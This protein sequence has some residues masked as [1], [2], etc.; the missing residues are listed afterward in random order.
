MRRIGQL[1]AQPRRQETRRTVEIDAALRQQAP[2]DLRHPEP[3]GDGLSRSCIAIAQTPTTAAHRPFDPQ[4]HPGKGVGAPRAVIH[5][6][7]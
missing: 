3:L 4:H 6:C 2:D 5:L 7:A 1:I